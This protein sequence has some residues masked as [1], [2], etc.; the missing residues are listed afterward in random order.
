MPFVTAGCHRLEYTWFG[1]TAVAARPIVMLHEGLGSLA[2]W[3]DFP[4]QLAAA[5]RR[6]VLA[7]SRYGYGASEPLAG[8]LGVDFM[9][10]EALETLPQL[11]DALEVREAVLFGHSQGASMAL[12]H[13][14]RAHRPVTAVMAMAPLVFVERYGLDSIRQAR[15]AFLDTELREKLARY[16]DDVESAFWGWNDIWLNPDFAS[17]SIEALLPEITC[18]V[19]TI[20]GLEDEYGTI[21]Q[22]ETS[23]KRCWR[24]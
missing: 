13:A 11:F 5:T 21:E 6:P 18:P 23:P 8:P 24:R 3:K 1:A 19:L 20:Q 2:Q 7:Y 14:A 4:E 12:I 17:W 15:L 16:H 10:I 22:I 9:H